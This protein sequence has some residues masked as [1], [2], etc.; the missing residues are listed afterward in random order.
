[1]ILEY[2]SRKSLQKLQEELDALKEAARELILE[3]EEDMEDCE[4][5]LPMFSMLKAK[6]RVR[7]L[8]GMECW[9]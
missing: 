4:E 3:I 7:E 5:H 1:M 9:T 8:L 6:N 2:V